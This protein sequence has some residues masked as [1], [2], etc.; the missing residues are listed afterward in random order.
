EKPHKCS[1]CGKSFRETTL[2]VRGVWE[3]LQVEI[4]C[5]KSFGMSYNLTRHRRSH[6]VEWPYECP[7]CGKSFCESANLIRHQRSRTEERPYEC[8]Q[9]GKSFSPVEWWLQS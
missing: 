3:E 2:L 7:E 1:E 6:T 8:G 5:D 9:C 4:L